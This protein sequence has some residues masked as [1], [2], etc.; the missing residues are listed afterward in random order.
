VN[1]FFKDR[2]GKDMKDV[3]AH[4]E[5]SISKLIISKGGEINEDKGS[6]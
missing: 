2:V 3:R 4:N 1:F 5:L 6:D